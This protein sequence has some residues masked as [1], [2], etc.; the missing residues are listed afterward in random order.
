MKEELNVIHS[1]QL[2]THPVF[3]P[4]QSEQNPPLLSEGNYRISS[5]YQPPY[6]LFV[7]GLEWDCHDLIYQV[8]QRQCR[9]SCESWVWVEISLITA[10]L[11]INHPTLTAGSLLPTWQAVGLEKGRVQNLLPWGRCHGVA[12]GVILKFLP[13]LSRRMITPREFL[14]NTPRLCEA[15]PSRGEE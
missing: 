11:N 9:K 13:E 12:E 7:I 15:L 8:S 6:H 4:E 3:C 2:L 14:W 5:I 1:W 10:K